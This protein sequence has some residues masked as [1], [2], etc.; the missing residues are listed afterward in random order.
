MSWQYWLGPGDGPIDGAF[1]LNDGSRFGVEQGSWSARPDGDALVIQMRLNI[2]G[3]SRNDVLNARTE[4]Q[5]LLWQTREGIGAHRHIPGIVHSI[6]IEQ[7][8]WAYADVL[9]GSIDVPADAALPLEFN[10]LR[11]VVLTLTC[12]RYLRGE[13]VIDAL[14][15][16]G[17]TSGTQLY[18][19]SVA[20]TAPAL[21]R[22]I[23][24]DTSQNGAVINR[25]RAGVQGLSSGL[26]ANDVTFTNALTA[27]A[28]VQTNGDG[29]DTV[30]ATY[31]TITAQSEWQ[32]VASLSRPS[33]RTSGLYDAYL[34]WRDHAAI[35][36]TPSEVIAASGAIGYVQ[37]AGRFASA[38]TSLT[39]PW[40]AP[41]TDGNLLLLLVVCG[42]VTVTPPGG[43]TL[44]VTTGTTRKASIYY[45]EGA[46]TESGDQVITFSGS[47]NAGAQ[48]W[49]YSGIAASGALDQY[50]AGSSGSGAGAAT[51]PTTGMTAQANEL[52]IA[53]WASSDGLV[54]TGL[55][56]T[57]TYR[58]GFGDDPDGQFAERVL[59]ATGTYDASLTCPSGSWNALIVTFKGATAV[60][61]TVAAGTY[62]ARVTALAADGESLASFPTSITLS[63][64][65]AI[66]LRWTAPTVGT[67][68][69]YRVY[70]NDGSGWD[71]W[72]TG[73]TATNYSITT[74]ASP[75][76]SASPP[77]SSRLNSE[78]RLR[79]G[80]GNGTLTRPAA[81]RSSQVAGG[82]W[83]VTYLDTIQLPPDAAGEDDDERDWT[84]SVEVR[85]DV[86]APDVDLDALILRPHNGCALDAEY[87]DSDGVRMNLG[88]PYDWT[89]DTRRDG[90]TS[91]TLSD[92]GTVVGGAWHSG[93]VLLYP[94]DNILLLLFDSIGGVSDLENVSATV[95]V[96]YTPRWDWLPGQ[97]WG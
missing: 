40:R 20:G 73:S 28:G 91:V 85:N 92:E 79:I 18:L 71:Y 70:L 21:G 33:V 39:V 88:S 30:G 96:D 35:I 9:S 54:Q 66:N 95:R 10:W 14:T 23:V 72:D 7:D 55:D 53:L 11:G 68:T 13:R 83:E 93:A 52:A 4:I 32:R 75:T 56:S 89:L 1:D 12:R 63:A 15:Q 57:W 94:G 90:R 25:I 74:T 6:N 49:E 46:T 61:P 29:T 45:K 26:Y 5:R 59:T 24:T 41:T 16:T 80:S 27:V 76:G 69:G 81:A 77:V 3:T 47:T 86:L 42:N 62:Q 82:V 31:S 51:T 44:A 58:G 50:P 37:A 97:D 60:A 84:V 64:A 67:V 19:P 43:W 65:G 36:G 22:L 34:R 87:V 78:A 17:V 8:E 38:V 48:L 2:I